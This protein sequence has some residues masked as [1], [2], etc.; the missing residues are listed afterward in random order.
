MPYRCC[1][2]NCKGNYPNTPKVAVFGFPKDV[3]LKK[4]WL[5]AIKRKDFEPSA[6]SK[7]KYY[8]TIIVKIRDK[9][10]VNLQ[11]THQNYKLVIYHSSAKV[12]IIYDC[13]CKTSNSWSY[14]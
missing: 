8:A 3:E 7:V 14:F 5:H 6:T 12:L 1:V 4:K 13:K 11:M 9:A 2:P 10:P